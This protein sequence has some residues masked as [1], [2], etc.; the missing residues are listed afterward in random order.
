MLAYKLLIMLQK[1]MFY[2]NIM[3]IHY[4]INYLKCFKSGYVIQ[5]YFVI[6]QTIRSTR[7]SEQV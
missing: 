5:T 7:E 3:T 6:L 2:S 4:L 1:W